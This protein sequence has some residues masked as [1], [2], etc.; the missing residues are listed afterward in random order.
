MALTALILLSAMSASETRP[1]VPFPFAAGRASAG[2]IALTGTAVDGMAQRRDQQIRMTGVPLTSGEQVDLVLRQTEALIGP[3]ALHFDGR[4]TGIDPTLGLTLWIGGIEGEPRSDAFLAFSEYGAW[5]WID[6]DGDRDHLLS[7]PSP[8]GAWDRYELVSDDRLVLERQPK[9][10]E[11]GTLADGGGVPLAPPVERAR[12]A[13]TG[14]LP[15]L[16]ARMALECDWHYYQVFGN[17][18]AAATYAVMLVGA[19]NSRYREQADVVMSIDYLNIWTTSNDPWITT[20]NGGTCYDVIYEFRGA[21]DDNGGAPIEA[22]LYHLFTGADTQCAIAWDD[23]CDPDDAWSMMGKMNG[24][25][26]FPIA[27]GPLNW[28]FTFFTHETGHNFGSPHTHAYCPPLDQCAPAGWF[29]PCQNLQVCITD[30]TFMSYCHACPGGISNF[31]T[32]FHPTVAGVLRTTAE[33]GCL[34]LFEGV[35]TEDLGESLVGSSGA[36]ELEVTYDSGPDILRFDVTGAPVARLGVFITSPTAVYL[37]FVGGGT[38]VPD[39]TLLTPT[40]VDGLGNSSFAA[41]VSGSYP[42]G[43]TLYTHAWFKD[44]SGPS[45]FA[46]SNAVRWE[47]I[48]P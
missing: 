36:P 30:G 22:D 25:T 33:R 37:P 10:L 32:W 8:S 28:D 12:S 1:A 38:L 46:G 23:V 35:L 34:A 27:V 26:P 48:R 16:V 2:R 18:M 29:G 20:D 13:A 4:P 15:V 42:L 6:H 14:S 45:G 7:W 24:Q 17:E 31:T 43:A 3:D 40:L 39:L 47:L 41:V 9:P 11:C 19:S 21:W 44:P 5:G